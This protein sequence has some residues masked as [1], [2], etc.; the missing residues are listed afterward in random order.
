MT[1]AKLAV[2][3]V[4]ALWPLGSLMAAAIDEAPEVIIVTG[5]LPGPPLWKVSNGDKVLWIFPHLYQ[6]PED[7]VWDSERVARVIADSQEF[8]DLPLVGWGVTKSVML[9][10]INILRNKRFNNRLALSP[11]GRNLE[12]TLPP[13][14]YARFAALRERYFAGIED[15]GNQRPAMV[16]RMMMNIVPRR[17]GLARAG[18]LNE[19]LKKIRAMARRN[20]D[21]K[22]TEILV[23]TWIDDFDEYAARVEAV[24]ENY[25]PE[26][27]QACFAQQVG[28]LEQD[29][30]AMKS[31][32]NSWAQGYIDEFRNAPLWELGESAECMALFRG[33]SSPE[34]A[35]TSANWAR[36]NQ[37][38]LDA[39]ENALAANASAF[40]IL[41]INEML[42]EDGLLSKLKA[43][44]YDIRE[45]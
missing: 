35:I 32:A 21:I 26:L 14:L 45:P 9:N 40:A 31:R 10:P 11:D 24:Y 38:W 34:Y 4:L 5:R 7:M 13:E 25:P 42:A 19:V 23:A 27:E 39:I 16:G 28:H 37:L 2:L 30:D 18:A 3:L 22:H 29:L 33:S 20:R 6:I 1:A 17:A 12:E 43:K 41:P 44:G 8:V 15:I 36:M